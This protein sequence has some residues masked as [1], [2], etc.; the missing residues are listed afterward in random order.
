M[1]TPSVVH[2]NDLSG[3]PASMIQQHAIAVEEDYSFFRTPADVH[4]QEEA[5]RL[6][7]VVS[8]ANFTLSNVSF[9][10]T[11]PEVLSF[12]EHFSA[13]YR[14]ATGSRLVVTSLTRPIALQPKNAHK[15]SVHP[16]GMAVDFRVPADATDRAWLEKALLA[17]EHDGMIDVTRE[18]HPAHYHIAVFAEPFLAYAAN[19]DREA[20]NVREAVRRAAVARALAFKSAS[21]AAE[22]DTNRA[23]VLL[24]G[25]SLLALAVPLTR[26][27]RKAAISPV[28]SGSA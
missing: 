4:K 20:D 13:D 1:A 16:A 7:P 11:R 21:D 24:A 14:A 18:K 15:L 5:G 27:A 17:M 8:G 26:R 22:G 9:P 12:I 2:A 23:P 6:V 28:A 25:L 19:R 10:S 3:S